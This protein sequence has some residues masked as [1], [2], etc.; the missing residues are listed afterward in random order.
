MEVFKIKISPEVIRNELVSYSYSSNT[1]G[2]Y[3]G[4]TNVLTAGTISLGTWNIGPPESQGNLISF[5]FE[6]IEG[7]TP[8]IL[9]NKSGSTGFDWSFYLE[10][11]RTGS[12]VTF[13][14]E[15]GNRV[16]YS[17]I[18][19]TQ[20]APN[21]IYLFLQ[22]IG[23]GITIPVGSQIEL[24]I[25]QLGTSQLI[26]L[27]IPI[28]L[29]QSYEDLGYYSPFDGEISQDNEEVNFT[30]IFSD[31]NPYEITIFNTSD[32]RKTYLQN[33]TYRIDWGDGTP[34]QEVTVFIPESISH[35]YINLGE[36]T[37]YTITFY[38]STQY[39][40]YEITK[41]FEV[42]YFNTT[43][44]DN[45]YG[46]INFITNNGSWSASPQTQN[47]IT[48]YDA[49]NSVEL[50]ASNNYVSVP[51]II[52]GFTTSRLNELKVYGLNPLINNLNIN[53]KDGTLGIVIS[54][55]VDFT[56]YT[57][58]E[59][60]YLDFADGSTVFVVQ[61]YGLT[62]NNFTATTITKMEYL[63]NII[64]QPEIQS[65]VF[66]ERGKNSGMENFRR[67]GEVGNTG[68]LNNYGYKF[69]DVRKYNEI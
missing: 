67:I 15:D 29:K 66:I 68:S 41:T 60:N 2:Y 39:N 22:L 69:F 47:F 50:Q 7:E 64:E 42:P 13:I 27:S 43:D 20:E 17:T 37:D 53:L 10:N 24:V 55:S 58:N 4:L 48:D 46:Q 59:Q 38:G 51:F 1:F 57:I 26:D 25:T 21:F 3:S 44:I 34:I 28:L 31:I 54:Q 62:E 35:T 61:S 18:Q 52:S 30:F 49:I 16:N 45:P 9:I 56:A 19:I 32:T 6:P 36:P 63:L 23:D 14:T 12:T 33:S 8:I 11:I 5:G 40:N 65:N